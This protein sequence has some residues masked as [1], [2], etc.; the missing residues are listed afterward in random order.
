LL[1]V[2]IAQSPLVVYPGGSDSSAN[3]T[4]GTNVAK[5]LGFK[6]KKATPDMV[7][8]SHRLTRRSPHGCLNGSIACTLTSVHPSFCLDRVCSSRIPGHSNASDCS[9]YNWVDVLIYA[10]GDFSSDNIH[11]D[12]LR[13]GSV[14]L[15]VNRLLERGFLDPVSHLPLYTVSCNSDVAVASCSLPKSIPGDWSLQRRNV[16]LIW[17]FQASRKTISS[18]SAIIDPA[19]PTAIEII[20]RH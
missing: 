18:T 2:I 1:V 16:Q 7:S 5:I 6:P 15:T 4:E 19:V 13:T 9:V 10:L 17:R 20:Q 11:Y 12:L 14:E 3:T 8:S